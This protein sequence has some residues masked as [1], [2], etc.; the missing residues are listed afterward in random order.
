ML[1]KMF[2]F[3]HHTSSCTRQ[4]FFVTSRIWKGGA[5]EFPT[6]FQLHCIVYS[7]RTT[8]VLLVYKAENTF[9]YCCIRVRSGGP[10]NS[11]GAN[12]TENT[13]FSTVTVRIRCRGNVFSE[14]LPRNEFLF[15]ESP[16]S[17]GSIRHINIKFRNNL[18]PGSNL[19]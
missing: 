15:T 18:S 10:R 7:S 8:P 3:L 4:I 14:S 19:K 9:L 6:L 17:N 5:T 11:L 2:M 13:P 16:L 1:L 12:H